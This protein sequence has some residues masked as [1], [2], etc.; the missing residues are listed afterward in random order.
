MKIDAVALTKTMR[1]QGG[2]HIRSYAHRVFEREA[3]DEELYGK[4]IWWKVSRRREP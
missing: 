3:W 4:Q 1:K 2:K